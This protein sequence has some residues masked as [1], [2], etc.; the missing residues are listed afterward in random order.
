MQA[1]NSAAA[2]STDDSAGL[3][4][5]AVLGDRA[6][7]ETLVRTHGPA[8]YRFARNMVRDDGL[9]EEIVQDAFVAAWK[10]LEHYRSESALRTWLFGIVNHKAIDAT[11]RR[12]PRPAEDWLFEDAVGDAVAADDPASVA[13]GSD[14][15]VALRRALSDLPEVQ[16][17]CWLLREVEGMTHVEIGETLSMSPSAV[18]GQVTRARR[19][20]SERMA[21]WR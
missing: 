8:M 18:R 13:T 14:F 2:A 1:T 10:S 21:P 15:L 12:V 5:A 7:F 17:S 16:R 6:A 3:V 20:L 9:A 4:N 19:T 11:R